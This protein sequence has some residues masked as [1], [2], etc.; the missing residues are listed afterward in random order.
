MGQKEIDK[1]GIAYGLGFGLIGLLVM[2]LIIGAFL[3]DFTFIFELKSYASQSL[4]VISFI[5]FSLYFGRNA[6]R[7]ILLK[8]HKGGIEG[9]LS[10]VKTLFFTGLIFGISI[11]FADL[12]HASP[13]HWETLLWYLVLLPLTTFAFGVLP[14]AIIGIIFGKIIESKRK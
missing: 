5:L 8:G 12:F 2:Y 13:F 6:S 4:I 11:L 1:I 7:K 3:N 9:A 10:S 14:A